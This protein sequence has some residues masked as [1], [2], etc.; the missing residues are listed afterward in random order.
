[1]KIQNKIIKK[2]FL[3]LFISSLMLS[4]ISCRDTNEMNTDGDMEEEETVQRE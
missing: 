1:M 2:L 4:A 3:S